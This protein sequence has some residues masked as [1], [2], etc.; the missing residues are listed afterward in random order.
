M[1]MT[2]HARLG[3]FMWPPELLPHEETPPYVKSISDAASA[4]GCILINLARLSE[5][6]ALRTGPVSCRTTS[7]IPLFVFVVVYEQLGY[8]KTFWLCQKGV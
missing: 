2:S 1:A 4:G 8:Y 7:R 5:W 3:V 6:G